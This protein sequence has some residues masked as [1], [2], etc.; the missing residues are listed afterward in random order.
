VLDRFAEVADRDRGAAFEVGDR[1][2]DAQD[3]TT[4]GRER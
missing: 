2:P 3:A 1:A 4:A